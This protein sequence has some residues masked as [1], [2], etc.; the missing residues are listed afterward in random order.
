MGETNYSYKTSLPAYREDA[1]GKQAQKDKILGEI[2]RL[3]D[4]ACLKQIEHF[5]TL[6]QSTC[7]GRINDLIADGKVKHDGYME[8]EGRLRK[9]FVLINENTIAPIP[10]AVPIPA[11]VIEEKKK[12]ELPVQ[13]KLFGT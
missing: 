1:T 8:F 4:G 5:M 6:P 9:R 10:I 13:Q 2:Q 7:S 11:P 3:K 12:T